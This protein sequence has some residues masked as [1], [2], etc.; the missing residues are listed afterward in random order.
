MAL[1]D[2]ISKEATFPRGGRVRKIPDANTSVEKKPR[3]EKDLFSS[4]ASVTKDVQA[5]KKQRKKKLAKEK[6]KNNE[7]ESQQI[8]AVETLSYGHLV[9]GMVIMGKISTIRELDLRI[10]LPGRLMAT[11]PITNISSSYTNALKDIAQGQKI[12]VDSDEYPR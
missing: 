1:S 4:S 6:A 10:S 7:D 8:E 2:V 12:E 9:E 5:Q 3:R 11:C